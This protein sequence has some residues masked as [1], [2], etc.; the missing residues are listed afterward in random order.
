MN[1]IS[2]GLTSNILQHHLGTYESVD[3]NICLMTTTNNIVVITVAQFVQKIIGRDCIRQLF[4]DNNYQC[5]V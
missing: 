2:I 5:P 4:Q 1:Y 3:L